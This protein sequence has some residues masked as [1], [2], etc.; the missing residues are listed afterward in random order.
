VIYVSALLHRYTDF[1]LT[2]P[3]LLPAQNNCGVICE[4][5]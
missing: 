2:S 5:L 4:N 1:F 3:I